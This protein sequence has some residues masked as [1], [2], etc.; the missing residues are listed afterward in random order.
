MGSQTD[1][2]VVLVTLRQECEEL[3]CISLVG[4]AFPRSTPRKHPACPLQAWV[5]ANNAPRPQVEIMP[6]NLNASLLAAG[7]V[8]RCAAERPSQACGGIDARGRPLVPH[9]GSSHADFGPW[10]RPPSCGAPDQAS[11]NLGH[12]HT[13]TYRIAYEA[14]VTAG[15]A[16]R[17]C[18]GTTTVCFA[19]TTAQ[20]C[21]PYD[22]TGTSQDATCG[23]AAPRRGPFGWS[24][25]RLA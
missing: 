3:A 24:G 20:Q 13:H 16:T 23:G 2:Q 4:L 21:A 14:T 7:K 1:A 8:F 25:R 18:S 10:R 6:Q 19:G 9:P 17:T 11:L 12:L 15:G 22:G 5:V